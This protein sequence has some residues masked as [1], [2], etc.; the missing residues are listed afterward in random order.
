LLPCDAQIDRIPSPAVE[1]CEVRRRFESPSLNFGIVGLLPEAEGGLSAG[2]SGFT[3]GDVVVEHRKKDVQPTRRV[4]ELAMLVTS[5]AP[6]EKA[7]YLP[8]PLLDPWDQDPGGD[9]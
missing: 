6:T 4:E 2:L 8:Q 7:V 1:E 9:R 3:I 5:H